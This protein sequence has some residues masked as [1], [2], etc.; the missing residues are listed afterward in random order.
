MGHHLRLVPPLEPPRKPVLALT[1]DGV[2]ITVSM[3]V[4][5]S[6]NTARVVTKLRCY[7]GKGWRVWLGDSDHRAGDLFSSRAAY[8]RSYLEVLHA[9]V[10]RIEKQL[11]LE[12]QAV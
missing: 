12:G 5:L 2:E 3:T 8:L 6:E 1:K 4:W 9:E 11:A 10:V 7:G